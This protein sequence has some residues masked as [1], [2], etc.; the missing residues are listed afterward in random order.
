M[1][2]I[3]LLKKQIEHER[4]ARMKAEALLQEKTM[5]LSQVREQ[6]H[7]SNANFERQ[8]EEG[9]AALQQIENHYQLL[10]ESLNDIIYK[11]TP[12]GFFTFVNP[13]VEQVL[14][15]K[16][17]EIVGKH[18]TELVLPDY[19]EPLVNFYWNMMKEKQGSTYIEFPVMAKDKIL[20]MCYAPLKAD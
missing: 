16:E 17:K 6:L 4:D 8:I 9:D 19:R 3:E 10:I 18:F 20:K 7:N 2:E 13:V 14:G 15:Y 5:Q 11:I 12:E 1:E